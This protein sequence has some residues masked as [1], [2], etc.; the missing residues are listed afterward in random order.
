MTKN[1]INSTE[2]A[3]S[4]CV[5]S[6]LK[7]QASQCPDHLAILSPDR[8]PLTYLKLYQQV[9]NIAQVLHQAGLGRFDRIA[10]VLP[11]GADMA[12][13]VLAVS[14]C[15]ICAPL[16]PGYQHAEFKFYLSDLS[17]KAV[18]LTKGDDSP[19]R[20]VA[21]QLGITIIDLVPAESGEAGMFSIFAEKGRSRAIDIFTQA[22]DVAL[23]LHTSGTTSRPKLVPLTQRNIISSAR[24]ISHVLKLSEDDRCLNMMPLFHIHGLIAALLSTLISG[25]A[26]V[27]TRGFIQD[28]FY[29]WLH[30]MK[31][32]WYSAVPTIH[33]AILAGARSNGAVIKGN[34]LRFIRS[35][36]SA[37]PPQVLMETEKVFNVPVI[38]AYGM[39][40]AAH[41]MTSNPLPPAQRK[42]RSVGVAAGPEVAI[43]NEDGDLLP[44]GS[45]GEIVI[46]GQNVTAG[47]ENNPEANESA[48]SSGWFRTGDQGMMDDDGYLFISDRIK[49]IINRG[50]EKVSP[51][52]VDEILMDHPDIQQAVAFAVPHPTLEEDVAAVVVLRDGAE[53][54]ES[55]IRDFLFGKLADFKIPSHVAIVDEIPKG[56][57]GKLQRIGLAEKLAD[58]LKRKYIAPRNKLEALITGIW[59]DVLHNESIGIHDNFFALG[60]D[61]LRATQVVSR[62]RSIFQ[63][64][65]NI[66]TVFEKPT[67]SELA[68]VVAASSG[69]KDQDVLS[70]II[71]EIEK[72]T[73]EEARKMLDAEIQRR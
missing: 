70:G 44:A 1:E 2:D 20:S 57:T 9:L 61:S 10:I 28:A 59:S 25:G 45:T 47:Y 19:A 24:N 55:M 58:H 65:L 26:I 71:G 22:D 23:L 31:P 46:R 43:M 6:M 41:Q 73:D 67:V 7:Y 54:T 3:Q 63:T 37:L 68:E 15:A 35:S 56:S 27:C 11:N 72:L 13:A 64:N 53:A 62:I 12:V 17:A 8:P 5:F 60:G 32:T 40:E 48:F 18:I 39:T 51:R 29:A 34:H 66:V 50:G 49:E 30:E 36:S 21:E 14:S 38:E 69:L 42:I 33:Q 52:E 16:N 4:L